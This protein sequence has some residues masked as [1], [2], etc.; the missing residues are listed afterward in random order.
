MTRIPVGGRTRTVIIWCGRAVVV[1]ALYAFIEALF[2][3]TV[4]ATKAGIAWIVAVAIGWLVLICGVAALVLASIRKRREHQAER[5]YDLA[6]REEFETRREEFKS[7]I[8]H[9][10]PT[11]DTAITKV[12]RG[13]P[14]HRATGHDDAEV[15]AK[16]LKARALQRKGTMTQ[17]QIAARLGTSAKTLRRWMDWNPETDREP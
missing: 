2:L 10:F 3:G 17:E 16:V 13:R 15:K 7:Q 14:K 8:A 5:A 4:P 11:M 1:I 9:L 6:L 12:R